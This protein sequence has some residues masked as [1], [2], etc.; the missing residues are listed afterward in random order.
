MFVPTSSATSALKAVRSGEESRRAFV[1]RVTVSR[2]PSKN[3]DVPSRRLHQNIKAGSH[4]M[5]KKRSVA[6]ISASR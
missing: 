1:K 3:E 5:S 6:H 4:E 2:N